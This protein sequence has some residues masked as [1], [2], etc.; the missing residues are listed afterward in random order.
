MKIILAIAILAGSLALIAAAGGPYNTYMPL[1]LR[2]GPTV[3]STSTPTRTPT[4]TRTAT[5]TGTPTRTPTATR[6]PTPTRTATPT[7]T[8]TRTPTNTP[9]ATRTPTATPSVPPVVILPQSSW[10]QS[11]TAY[12]RIIGEVQN[13]SNLVLTSVRVI[14]NIFSASGQFVGTDTATVYQ[15]HLQ[16]GERACFNMLVSEPADWSYYEF[17]TPSYSVTSSQRPTLS[18]F[19]ENAYTTQFG[20]YEIIGFVQND[21]TVQVTSTEIIATVYSDD[22][23]PLDCSSRFANTSTLNPGENS[24]FK[25]TMTGRDDYYD[26]ADYSLQTDGNRQ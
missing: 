5:P 11:S 6:T 16:P 12:I 26:V 9:T 25:I 23:T 10:Y 18:I 21:D 22:G 4:P 1:I 2:N 13:N 20:W 8:P 17:Q 24:S 15:S 7:H 3:T 14:A 19:N